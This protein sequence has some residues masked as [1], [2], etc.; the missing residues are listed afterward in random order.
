MARIDLHVHTHYSPDAL[1]RPSQVVERAERAGLTHVAITDHG[2]TRGAKAVREAARE[3]GSDLVVIVGEEIHVRGGELIGLFLQEDLA[4]GLPA[5]ETIEAIRAQA[6]IAIAPHPFDRFRRGL[7][8]R[9]SAL[10]PALDA[11]EGWNGRMLGSGRNRRAV[12]WAAGHGLP[13]TLGSD[14]HVAS[15]LGRSWSELP[16]FE[17]PE[18][19]LEALWQ[20]THQLARFS[21][22]G[23]LASGLALARWPVMR[24]RLR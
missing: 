18:E 16:D 17:G 12:D 23:P 2:T 11:V 7:G 24:H 1:T 6:G 8:T 22:R 9:L 21:P 5:N 20:A 13:V 19:L 3:A 14:T 4:R 15:D 10:A